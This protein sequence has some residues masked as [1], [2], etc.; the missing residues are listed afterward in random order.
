MGHLLSFYECI[1]SN[2]QTKSCLWLY[3][4]F[5]FQV[6]CTATENKELFAAIPFCYG[7]LGFLTCIDIDIIPYK[8]YIQLTYHNV[9]SLDE[10]VDKFT[11]VTNDPDV[12]SVEGHMYTLNSGVIMSG[13]FVDKVPKNAKYN[14]VSRL[15]KYRKIS[16]NSF[17]S[18]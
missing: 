4:Y 5:K 6:N 15:V 7:T 18:I 10:V 17:K 16:Y 1:H 12:D 8:P 9:R 13:K 14:P 11:E 3:L 2:K